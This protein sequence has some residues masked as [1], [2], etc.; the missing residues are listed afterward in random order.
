MCLGRFQ[1]FFGCITPWVLIIMRIGCAQMEKGASKV[2]ISV[3]NNIIFD[4]LESK[5]EFSASTWAPFLCTRQKNNLTLKKAPRKSMGAFYLYHDTMRVCSHQTAPQKW[6]CIWE[7]T[8]TL[9]MPNK[10]I[11]TIFHHDPE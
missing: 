10:S 1:A 7:K 2:T 6:I 9:S 8:V 5:L 4:V 3:E 11:W